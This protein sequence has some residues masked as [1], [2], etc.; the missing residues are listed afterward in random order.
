[1]RNFQYIVFIWSRA[2]G[3]IFK[4]LLVYFKTWR[5]CVSCQFLIWI[6]YWK[7]WWLFVTLVLTFS[8]RTIFG[9]DCLNLPLNYKSMYIIQVIWVIYC[10]GE[11]LNSALVP[12]H[13]ILSNQ[14]ID[15]QPAFTY[16]TLTIETLEQCMKYVQ[17]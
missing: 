7:Y 2:Y 3:E 4:S 13:K 6:R 5:N 16:S 17:S 10:Y 11:P 9:Q 8:P 15:S 14:K 1:M 12:C